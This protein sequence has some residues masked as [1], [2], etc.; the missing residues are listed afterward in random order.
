MSYLFTYKKLI[1]NDK[2]ANGS[3]NNMPQPQQ[4]TT[5]DADTLTVSTL[6]T[7][8]D[9]FKVLFLTQEKLCYELRSDNAILKNKLEI[10]TSV[11]NKRLQKIKKLQ[12]KICKLEAVNATFEKILGHSNQHVNVTNNAASLRL[13]PPPPPPPPP[14]PQLTIGIKQT[15]PPPKPN[16]MNNVLEEFKSK[17]TPKD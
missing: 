7:N 16:S 11:S 2:E 10:S 15:Q 9:E 6:N 17:F 8:L 14:P 3:S 4:H 12:T 5:T 13:L 1:E